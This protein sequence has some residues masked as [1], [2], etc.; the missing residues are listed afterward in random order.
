MFQLIIKNYEFSPNFVKPIRKSNI[1]PGHLCIWLS[2]F[3]DTS[4]IYK[5]L[6]QRLLQLLHKLIMNQDTN[7]SLYQ[8]A[9]LF[10]IGL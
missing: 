4:H 2:M 3:C 9:L 1:F 10:K 7:L 6:W 5:C 8:A